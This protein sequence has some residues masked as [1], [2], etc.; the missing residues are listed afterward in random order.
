[1]EYGLLVAPNLADL[2]SQLNAVTVE[3]WEAAGSPVQGSRPSGWFVLIRRDSDA[4][5]LRDREWRRELSPPP[6]V[7]WS[8]SAS[9]GT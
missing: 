9:E 3:G 1:M 4:R 2:V 7:P 5:E 6:S 8:A